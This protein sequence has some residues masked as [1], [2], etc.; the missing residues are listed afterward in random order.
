MTVMTAKPPS[1]APSPLPHINFTNMICNQCSIP[2][3]LGGGHV[4]HT[5]AGS[6]SHYASPAPSQQDRDSLLLVYLDAVEKL[7]T[8][9]N[10]GVITFLK[11]GLRVVRPTPPFHDRDMI[12]LRDCLVGS[13][14]WVETI[15]LSLAAKGASH[16]S[17]LIRGYFVRG[18]RSYGA[19]ALA[20]V[21]RRCPTL[22]DI[23][24]AGNYIG[25]Y[26]G[27]VIAEAL[28]EVLNKNLLLRKV[29]LRGCKISVR[30][31]NA[32]ASVLKRTTISGEN[33]ELD[34]SNNDMGPVAL[35]ALTRAVT[36]DSN[37]IVDVSGNLVVV[38]VLNAVTHGVGILLCIFGA[39]LMTWKIHEAGSY[40]NRA[41]ACIVIYNTSLLA[42]YIS[43]TL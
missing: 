40:T 1:P 3:L 27:E 11:F 36:D 9:P 34:L 42:L 12:A 7:K 23:R 17:D 41:R 22:V 20:D 25:G 21:I 19:V 39:L 28:G 31:G 15:D 10:A 37:V 18:I 16:A 5:I 33:L 26:G 30:G 35:A 38:E 13:P 4:N 32:F 2:L 6:S 8:R 29:D 24:L 14:C 43:S